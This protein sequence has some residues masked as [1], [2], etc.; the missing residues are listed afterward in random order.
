MCDN[1]LRLTLIKSVVRPDSEADQGRHLVMEALAQVTD[2]ALG[3]SGGRRL[4][5]AGGETSAAVCRRL[6]VGGMRVLDEIEPG[7]AACVTL[8]SLPRLLVLKSG[9]F[10][11]ASFLAQAIAHL[12]GR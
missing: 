2:R 9:S 11:S 7:V 10:G 12:A 8:G 1:V 5:V 4:V 3:R 6:G